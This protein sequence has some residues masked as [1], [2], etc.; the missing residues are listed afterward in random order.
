MPVSPGSGQGGSHY[1]LCHDRRERH[2]AGPSQCGRGARRR[3]PWPDSDVLRA[4]RYGRG[5]RHGAPVSAVAPRRPAV[6]SRGAGHER[7]N[8]RHARSGATAR[9]RASL[10][11]RSTR[12][13]R[14]RR[15]RARQHRGGGAC[16]RV[17]CRR[18]RGHGA[19]RSRYR[20]GAQGV[21]MDPHRNARPGRSRWF[22]IWPRAITSA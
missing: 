15:R 11:P 19:D 21:R 3:Q 22:R 14:R 6:R 1:Q 5:C 13:G 2:R 18:R 16:E 12:R 4:C 7:G 8:R 9:E 20:S 17:A 10:P